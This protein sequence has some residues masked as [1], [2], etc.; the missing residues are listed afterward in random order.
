MTIS[1]ALGTLTAPPP[2]MKGDAASVRRQRLGS[3]MSQRSRFGALL[4]RGAQE[5]I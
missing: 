5:R 4:S 2:S 1:V 3:P